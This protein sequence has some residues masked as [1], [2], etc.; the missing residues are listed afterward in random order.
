MKWHCNK[1]AVIK[2]TRTNA[3]GPIAKIQKY[4]SLNTVA[5]MRQASPA[6]QIAPV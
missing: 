2:K 4:H 6:K 5:L 3:S 1:K